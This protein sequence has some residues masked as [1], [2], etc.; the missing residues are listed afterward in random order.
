MLPEKQETVAS[1]Y[2]LRAGLS[3]LSETYDKAREVEKKI[4]D[5][6]EL[7]A[8]Q[9]KEKQSAKK[10]EYEAQKESEAIPALKKEV[11]ACE[12]KL[13]K[14]KKRARASGRAEAIA[15]LS[16]IIGIISLLVTWIGSMSGLPL[17]PW[18]I[19]LFVLLGISC[20]TFLVTISLRIS[21]AQGLVSKAENLWEYYKNKL[22]YLELDYGSNCEK[23]EDIKNETIRTEESANKIIAA[24]EKER[25][26]YEKE[27]AEINKEFDTVYRTTQKSFASV[28]DERDW[29]NLDLVI[30]NY[31]TGRALDLRDALMQVDMER[32]NE[33]LVD[34]IENAS[35]AIS[36]SIRRGFGELGGRIESRFNEICDV[37]SETNS[38]A[39]A[40][41]DAVQAS[42]A[43]IAEISSA[44]EALQRKMETSSDTMAQD[45]AYM[46]DL[47]N[48]TYYGV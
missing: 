33:R 43:R 15:V 16:A 9:E 30:F 6:N 19:L 24:A 47:A 22:Y 36:N 32:R 3:V 48:R 23:L 46:R 44:Q 25:T 29:E 35:Y 10:W 17:V 31:E 8:E 37:L 38:R 34:A 2:A 11:V 18:G 13:N 42:L 21:D 7:I 41:G 4:E 39:L 27:L 20:I 40:Q 14:A 26:E 1:L 28:M 12:E 5:A 45:I